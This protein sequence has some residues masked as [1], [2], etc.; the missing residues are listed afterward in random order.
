MIST[1]K[2]IYLYDEPQFIPPAVYAAEREEA[3]MDIELQ[4]KRQPLELR[5]KVQ[6]SY[7]KA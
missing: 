7:I 4:K 1:L 6:Q 2:A 5:I 3:M